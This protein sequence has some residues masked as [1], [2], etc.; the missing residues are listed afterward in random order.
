MTIT[1]D[2]L[3][4]RPVTL[5]DARFILEANTGSVRDY[6]IPFDTSQAVQE[7]IQ[8]NLGKMERGEKLELVCVRTEDEQPIG[9]VAVD[10]LQDPKQIVPRLWISEAFQRQGFASEALSGLLTA[11]KDKPKHKNKTIVYE[12]DTDNEA[13]IKLAQKIGFTYQGKETEDGEEYLVFVG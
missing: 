8:E 2:R 3:T 10:S 1:T 11:I 9:M 5:Q 7:W 4:L 12:V 13:S 6:F